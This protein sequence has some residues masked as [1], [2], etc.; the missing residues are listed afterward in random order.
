M[1]SKANKQGGVNDHALF[2]QTR[3]GKVKRPN[4]GKVKNS[5]AY[6]VSGKVSA[7]NIGKCRKTSKKYKNTHVFQLFKH[8]KQQQHQI[9]TLLHK[10]DD[11][12]NK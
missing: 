12:T 8:L 11:T 1:E 3:K 9:D 5:V 10:Y 6:I 7:E 4:K 2:G